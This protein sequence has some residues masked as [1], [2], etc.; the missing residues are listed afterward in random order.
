MKPDISEF[1]YGYALTD[2]LI[3]WHGTGITA[4]PI[5]PSLYDERQPGGGYD[6]KLDRGGI[7]LFLQFKLSDCMVR[8]TAQE[9]RSGSFSC[10]F[11]RIAR[12]NTATEVTGACGATL[13][14]N[15]DGSG[16]ERADGRGRRLSSQQP[17]RRAR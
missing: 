9:V 5:F 13:W 16:E 3:H 14:P 10:P 12:T 17:D 6:V 11:Y 15:R 4:V 8:G 1:S 2:E 7:P